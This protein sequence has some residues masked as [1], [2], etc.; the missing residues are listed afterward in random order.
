[1]RILFT[2][3][4]LLLLAGFAVATPVRAV[5]QDGEVSYQADEIW[6]VNNG[7]IVK[8]VVVGNAPA[9]TI[10]GPRGGR[11]VFCPPGGCPP[12][13]PAPPAEPPKFDFPDEE[14]D[15][16]KDEPKLDLPPEDKSPL[17]IV[18]YGVA[19]T[20]GIVSGYLAMRPSVLK[21][22]DEDDEA[23]AEKK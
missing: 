21:P 17:A 2:V 12:Q 14:P 7:H 15:Q 8:R 5:P 19:A 13:Q 20:G 1:M 3:C 18:L 11:I 4:L 6:I 10:Y 16:P 22:V 9:M 23:P